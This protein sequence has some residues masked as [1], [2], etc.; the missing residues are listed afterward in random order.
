[1]AVASAA[2]LWA[3][4]WNYPNLHAMLDTGACLLSGLLA[5]FFWEMGQRIDRALP[6]WIGICFFVTS[7]LECLHALVTVEWFGRL[8]PIAHSVDVLRPASWPPPAHLLPI[9]IICSVWLT[10]RSRRLGP[11]P[12]ASGLVLLSL[13]LAVVFHLLPRYTTPILFD[14]TR[15][16]LIFVPVLWAIAG[17]SCWRLRAEDR[18]LPTLI[19]MAAVLFL[20]HVSMLYSRAPHDT[21]VMA[22]ICAK[23][24]HTWFYFSQ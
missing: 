22:R 17:W 5:L 14:I 6:R 23:S 9:G 12:F 4:R 16:T 13:G 3:G 2:M 24:A 10:R 15:P 1:M 19:L 20:A 7:L 18:V 8:A 11:L 21:E